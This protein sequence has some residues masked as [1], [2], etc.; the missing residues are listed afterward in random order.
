MLRSQAWGSAMCWTTVPRSTSSRDAGAPARGLVPIL[1]G[2]PF[3]LPRTA[4]T[5]AGPR[6]VHRSDSRSASRKSA[7]LKARRLIPGTWVTPCF[8]GVQG[9]LAGVS[10]VNE[11]LRLVARLLAAIRWRRCAAG[12]SM[13]RGR[14]TAGYSSATRVLQRYGDRQ[15][16]FAL[17][18]T[19]GTPGDT[20]FALVND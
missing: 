16:L 12:S 2:L 15:P 11:R 8:S 14:T 20:F 4:A 10:Q 5:L 7:P 18:A 17:T 6:G 13:S 9:A 3:V 19:C 1:F